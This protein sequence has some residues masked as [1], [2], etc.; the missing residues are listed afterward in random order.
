MPRR[1][2]VAGGLSVV[3]AMVAAACSQAA[4][5]AP[6]GAKKQAPVRV[7]VPDPDNLQWMNFWTALGAGYFQKAGVPLQVVPASPPAAAPQMLLQGQAEVAV[8]APPMYVQ[9]VAQARPIRIFANLFQNDPINVVVRSDVVEARKLSPTAPLAERLRGM[10][11]LKVGVAPGPVN[12]LRTLFTSVGL[13][14]ERDIQ[15]VIVDGSAQNQ[16]F[17]E[18]RVDAL[19]A[20]TPYLETALVEQGGVLVVNQSRGEVPEL[21]ARQVHCLVTTQQFTSANRQVVLALTGAVYR[22]QQLIHT[23]PKAA[24]DAILRSGVPGLE[25]RKVEALVAIYQPAIPKTPE[26]SAEGLVQASKQ[27]V[28]IGQTP[29]DL[30]KV[31]IADYLA[32]EFTREVVSGK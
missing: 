12:R 2:V 17:G 9:L 5:L 7:V 25:Q 29:P 27:Y 1:H 26:V 19:Y 4:M 16:S 15:T 20:H 31:N 10:Q 18:K 14:A 13:D 8:L 24:A 23:D 6:E 22:A 21:A 32:P 30:T 28:G 3:G 11:G